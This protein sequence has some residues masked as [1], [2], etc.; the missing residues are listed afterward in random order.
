MRRVVYCRYHVPRIYLTRYCIPTCDGAGCQSTAWF[1]PVSLRSRIG[2]N[3]ARSGRR[4]GAEAGL[5]ATPCLGGVERAVGL[6]EDVLQV[7]RLG[8]WA[9][10][11]EGD[12]DTERDRDRC[13]HA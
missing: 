10:L 13:G 11:H 6:F 12:A 3:G 1:L 4:A 8:A 5:V 7:G 9:A 2:V